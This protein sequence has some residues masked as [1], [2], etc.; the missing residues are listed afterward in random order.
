MRY[1]KNGKIK[2]GLLY[3]DFIEYSK[4]CPICASE[5]RAVTAPLKN[6]L[7][8]YLK[9][10]NCHAVSSSHYLNEDALKKLYSSFYSSHAVYKDKGITH[11]NVIKFSKHIC[12]YLSF[13]GGNIS[14]LD[15]GGGSGKISYNVALTLLHGDNVK[16]VDILVVDYNAEIAFTSTDPRININRISPDE[17]I[18]KEERT[19]SFVIASAV[20]EHV[21]FAEPLIEQLINSLK[22]S[23]YLYVRAP[24]I[25]PL[26]KF[27]LNFG[28]EIDT[29]FPY[30]FHDF[31]GKY[32]ESIPE[33]MGKLNL[34]IIVSQPSFFQNS[35]KTHFFRSLVSRVIRFPYYLNRKY[36]FVGGW[37]IIYR[38]K[39]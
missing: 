3:T 29:D 34:E 6:N 38:R 31:S 8:Q 22:P 11:D 10:N 18:E 35:F 30:H 17:F 26:Y 1:A 7:F 16:T 9:C 27:L 24:Y 20:L 12:R 32:F 25:I 13:P 37:E 4:K 21:F 39:F 36:P 2:E 15:Y 33:K 5:D 23:G 19:F 28:I 14:I